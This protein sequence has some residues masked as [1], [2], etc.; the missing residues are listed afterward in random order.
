MDVSH[1]TPDVTTKPKCYDLANM[2]VRE[3]GAVRLSGLLRLSLLGFL[4]AK[5]PTKPRCYDLAKMLV[6]WLR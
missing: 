4:D 6:R 3:S 1:E 5:I 2:L